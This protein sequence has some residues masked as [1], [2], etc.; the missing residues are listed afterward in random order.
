MREL[1]CKTR[2]GMK[3]VNYFINTW[4]QAYA[5]LLSSMFFR[6]QLSAVIWLKIMLQYSFIFIKQELT[7]LLIHG[8][9]SAA[10]GLSQ[11]YEKNL[12]KSIDVWK[13]V[14]K[15]DME[16]G[17]TATKVNETGTNILWSQSIRESRWCRKKRLP[18]GDWCERKGSEKGSRG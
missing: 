12:G 5:P 10:C 6:S 17:P 7:L 9:E 18:Q 2:K 3:K 1:V 13:S 16:K 4:N 11:T 15:R 14:W 8:C